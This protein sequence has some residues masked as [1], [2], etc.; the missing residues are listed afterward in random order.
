MGTTTNTRS[1]SAGVVNLASGVVVTDATPTPLT[2]NVGFVPRYI[3]FANVAG[4]GV[5]AVAEWFD[6]MPSSVAA[7]VAMATTAAGARALT[8]AGAGIAVGTPALGSAGQFTV[9]AAIAVA[10]SS[11]AWQAMG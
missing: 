6:G 10:S 5:G 4:A 7:C 2:F 8:A 9:P 1:N 11:F 3:K